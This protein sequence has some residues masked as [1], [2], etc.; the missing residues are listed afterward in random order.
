TARMLRGALEHYLQGGG[1][2]AKAR[3]EALGRI[4]REQAFT[5]LNRLCALR[6]TEARGILIESVARG[7]QSRGF[8]LYA[9]LAGPAL[10][11]TGDAYRAYLHSVWDELALDLPV[12]FDRWSAQGRLFP[13]EAALL[14]LLELVNDGELEGLWAEDETIG[15]IYQYFNSREERRA[16]RAASQAPRNSRELAVRNQFF[17]PRY[18]VEFLTDNTLGRIWYEMTRGETPLAERC[19]YLVRRPREV[20]LGHPSLNH[21]NASAWVRLALQGDWEALPERPSIGEI[22]DFALLIDGYALAEVQG[23][24]DVLA[25]ASRWMEQH[26][27]EGK[28]PPEDPLEA[29]LMLFAYQRGYLRDGTYGRE[30]D[31]EI[32][33]A[34][35]LLYETVRS[36]LRHPR[37][38][39]SQEELLRQPIFIPQRKARDPRTITMLDPACGS[40]HFGLYAFDL[41]EVM[42]EEGWERGL[43]APEDYGYRPTAT[44]LSETVRLNPQRDP[45]SSYD[46]TPIAF[47]DAEVVYLERPDMGEGLWGLGPYIVRANGRFRVPV[48]QRVR[49]ADW[50]Y[51]AALEAGEIDEAFVRKAGCFDFE[52]IPAVTHEEAYTRFRRQIPR[53]IVEH[54]I[55]GVD[56]D[57]RAV[58]IAALSLWLRAQRAWHGQGVRPADRPAIQRSNVVVA[59]PMPGDKAMLEEFLHSLRG[60]RL[61]T[62]IRRVLQVPEG[63]RVR[64][65][66]AMVDALGDLARAVWKEMELA[67][68]A[69]SLLKIEETLQRAI[70]EGEAA[71]GEKLPLFRVDQYRMVE[72]RAEPTRSYR[73]AVPGASGDFWGSAETLVLAALRE[74]AE[75]GESDDSSRRRFFAED[76]AHGFAFIDLCRKKYDVVLMNPPFGEP[77]RSARDYIETAFPRTK[78]DVYA[79]FIERGIQRQVAQGR[80]GAITSR[81]GFFLTSFREWRDSIVLTEALPALLGD[82]GYGVLDAAMVETAMYVLEKNDGRGNDSGMTW[83][84]VLKDVDKERALTESIHSLSVGAFS[85]KVGTLTAAHIRQIPGAPFAYWVSDKVRR[86]FVKMDRVESGAREVRIGP[87]TGDD[88]RYVRLCWEVPPKETGRQERW[89]WLNKGGT[90]SPF[91]F[92]YHL[93]I[94]WDENRRTFRGFVGRPGRPIQRPNGL[95]HFFR[96]G[97]SWP[98]RTQ[99]GFNTRVMPG[100]MIFS[101]KGPA[102][103]VP[104]DKDLLVLLALTRSQVFRLMV[105]LQVSF[106]SYEVGA[107]QRTVLPRYDETSKQMLAGLAAS[108]W[109]IKHG[110]DTAMETSRA[111]TLPAVLQTNATTLISATSAWCSKLG[112]AAESVTDLQAKIDLLTLNLY[113]LTEADLGEGTGEEA[114]PG[115]SK[116]DHATEDGVDGDIE[117]KG[118]VDASSATVAV[119]SYCIGSILGRWDIRYATGEKEPPELP[120]PFAPLPV[121]PPGMLQNT[122]GLPAVSD[123]VRAS[124]Q[125][126]ISWPGILV[127]DEGHTEDVERRVREALE[128]VWAKRAGEIEHEACEILGVRALRDYFRKPGAFFADHLKRY[129]KSRRVAPIYWPLSTPSGGYTLWLYYHRLTDQTLYTCVN[130]FVDP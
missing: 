27:K 45:I 54:N 12:L 115:E 109:S 95:E 104:D 35:R 21:D 53:L 42:Y 129:S 122:Q 111:F 97:V 69:G 26:L 43:I 64:A 89:V 121:C 55:H 75:Q 58:Q 105:Q 16:M 74:Y 7:F 84:R 100:G 2:T 71:W 19:R 1:S 92:D 56:I 62:V 39:L 41:F 78:N 128:V 15:W 29:W 14:R 36:G 70:R 48:T 9:R 44:F 87:S 116:R 63:T 93:V 114:E 33:R 77:T 50:N 79:A 52:E 57:P 60:D 102:I 91:Y 117:D 47:V 38:D 98:L 80:L 76:A 17:T 11:E 5:V 101:H 4:V 65:T 99:G 66:P 94:D 124:Y 31:D 73:R 108:A 51:R 30:E 20:F 82:L 68:E 126:R 8:Q 119:L 34:V 113:G 72:E 110:V 24:G 107:I 3:Q 88:T 125:L 86:L 130:D 6:M 83:F 46:D 112:S 22:G 90:A 106:G 103:F 81:S 25:F 49:L 85:A 127:D 59:E 61:E 40:M 18:V 120:D 23:Y 13:R 32:L 118:L 37:E 67:G 28:P 123:D 96:P 10:G